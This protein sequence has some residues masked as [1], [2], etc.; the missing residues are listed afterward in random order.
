M[1]LAFFSGRRLIVAV[2]G[3]SE[4]GRPGWTLAVQGAIWIYHPAK[5]E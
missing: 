1:G 2:D 3:E 4:F 5:I